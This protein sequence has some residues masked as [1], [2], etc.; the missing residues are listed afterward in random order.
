MKLSL[1][2][3]KEYTKIVLPPEELKEKLDVS[4]TE[5]EHIYNFG[6][7]YEGMI[8]AKV[9]E[10]K[11]HPKSDK[12]LVL[13]LDLGN[14]KDV[15]VVV[16]QCPVKPGDKVVYLKP[17]LVVPETINKKQDP[18]K[19]ESVDIKGVNSVGM[20]PSGRELELNYDHTTVYTL[21]DDTKIGDE[22]VHA[23]DLEDKILEIENKHLTNRPDC[24]GMAGLAREISAVQDTEYKELKWLREPELIKPKTAENRLPVKV[25]IQAET[26]CNRYMAVV[27][28]NVEIK[29][30]PLWLQIRLAKLG[31][32]PVNNV[33]DISNYLMLETA[34]PS[35]AFDYDAIVS[36]DP[37]F[38]GT[39]VIN[40]RLAK[41]S[42]K[43]TTIDGELKELYSDTVII[44]DHKSPLGIAGVMGGKDT[45]ITNDTNR[46]IF[47]VES[48]DM[49][50]I[51]KTSKKVGIVSDASSRFSRGQDPNKCE[52]VL[53]KAVEML[54]E[55]AGAEIASE[56]E[57]VYPDPERE[58]FVHVN[59]DF[60]RNKI[61]K[62]IE[63]EEIIKT[64]NNLGLRTKYDENSG[65]ITVTAPTFRPDIRIP[66]DIV[67]EVARI[68]G[69]NNIS[70]TLP[71]KRINPGKIN[72]SRQKQLRIKHIMKEMG[73]NELYTYS[74]VGAE[75]YS[76]CKLSLNNAHKIRNALSP[77]L[78]YMRPVL[79]PSLLEKVPQNVKYEEELALF[80]IDKINPNKKG[81]I[82]T[83]DLPEEPVH[84][85][86]VHTLSYYHAKKYL[87]TLMENLYIDEYEI[88]PLDDVK[89]DS[90]PDWV[91]YAE[92]SYHP[93]RTALIK[94]GESIAGIIGE[95]SPNTVDEMELPNNTSVF[96]LRLEDFDNYIKDIPDYREPSKFPAVIQDFSFITEWEVRYDSIVDTIRSLDKDRDVIQGIECIDIY[97]EYDETK[98]TTIRVEFRSYEK[99]LDEE[100]IEE[101]R[102]E[103]ISEVEKETGG[104]LAK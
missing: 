44:A 101:L 73:A 14:S 74:F 16:Q 19:V 15:Q 23:L 21:P 1:N 71:K 50:N 36:R 95:V 61:G 79:L 27:L 34:Q 82:D 45:E 29:P 72:K 22:L 68:H 49:Y 30:S 46:V 57:D 20:V 12:L 56:I 89:D 96:E 87:E 5:V 69:Y 62:K 35:H 38:D 25:N 41:P 58:H 31:I 10:V 11:N 18:I 78:E 99:T 32:R 83:D 33:V 104:E 63:N 80:E 4:L 85:G 2:W 43:L 48:L 24:F 88:L 92:N 59:T 100:E 28:D 86:L 81:N 93:M 90:K 55:L 3:I 75:L 40:V 13:I 91:K 76:A 77:D 60:I 26:F 47:Q 64:L 97:S 84:I 9:V 102:N 51:R 54:R 94:I 65:N 67:E 66:A 42:E 53:Y 103:I 39:A 7:K 8:V 70:P 98:K 6:E 37:E 52:P 17:G